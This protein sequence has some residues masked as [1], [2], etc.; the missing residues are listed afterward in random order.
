[1]QLDRVLL[2][3]IAASS[4]LLG[5]P[6][7]PG[8]AEAQSAT[9]P[10]VRGVSIFGR[11]FSPSIYRVPASSQIRWMNGDRVA[12]NVTTV[13]EPPVAFS[14]A[15][16]ARAAGRTPCIDTA[17]GQ[18]SCPTF[19]GPALPPGR[20]PYVCTIHRRMSGT[21]IVAEG[22]ATTLPSPRPPAPPPTTPTT[23]RAVSILGRDLSPRIIRVPQGGRLSFV[24]GS[25]EQHWLVTV[26]P[27]IALQSEVP[28]TP[29]TFDTGPIAAAARR[30]RRARPIRPRSRASDRSRYR[31]GPGRGG[32]PTP[33]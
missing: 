26:T 32:T 8:M 3:A 23:R 18:V 29:L 33:A 16:P 14:F 30:R 7:A 2:V 12:H 1:V 17:T 13:G 19:T 10:G 22:R 4:V 27:E 28:G 11:S 20:Y 21:L 6:G 5:G 31:P 9:S 15:L 24:N 25:P